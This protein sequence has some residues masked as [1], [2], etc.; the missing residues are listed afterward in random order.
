M[1]ILLVIT[2]L[3]TVTNCSA[4]NKYK[5]KLFNNKC[6]SIE[7]EYILEPIGKNSLKRITIK[8]KENLKNNKEVISKTC[9][10]LK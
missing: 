10:N 7:R 4:I 5:S 3:L 9:P 8:D 1:K 2:I 6:S